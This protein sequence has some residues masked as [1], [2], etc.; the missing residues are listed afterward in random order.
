MPIE[1]I[2]T[3]V[4]N[5]RMLYKALNTNSIEL[6]EILAR[7]D[8]YYREVRVS[9]NGKVRITYNIK[10]RLRQILN[11]V[12]IHIFGNV[13][14]PEYLH[15]GI[16][17]RSART[18][19]LK[20]LNPSNIITMDIRSFFPSITYKHVCDLFYSGFQLSNSTSRKLADL[21]TYKG[22][23]PQGSPVSS[24]A[25]NCIFHNSE[26]RLEEYFARKGY[27]YTRFVDDITVSSR[28]K[29]T[30]EEKEEIKQ[31][32]NQFIRRHGFRVKHNKT[33]ISNRKDPKIISGLA[34]DSGTVKVPSEY[35]A[36]LIKEINSLSKSS[37][38]DKTL[39]KIKGKI[40]YVKSFSGK[41]GKELLIFLMKKIKEY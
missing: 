2:N 33:K 26:G 9:K 20:H 24:F 6:E 31:R 36:N 11:A 29:L 5:N 34:V 16:R 28:H 4:K 14:Y 30:N 22:K 41:Q 21:I 15:G 23:L 35:V 40:Y 18:N 7:K 39:R 38:D 12:K 17:N 10:G 19:A 1:Y 32:I 25:A 37:A 8:S 3:P 13:K 27:K